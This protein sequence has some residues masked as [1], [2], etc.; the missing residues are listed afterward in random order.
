MAPRYPTHVTETEIPPAEA[1]PR[2]QSF[3]SFS[4]TLHTYSDTNAH[5]T[6]HF[7]HV[8]QAPDDVICTAIQAE[9][10]TINHR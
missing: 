7:T 4:A 6:R 8:T 5:T 3:Q 10:S 1:T 9:S 2:S